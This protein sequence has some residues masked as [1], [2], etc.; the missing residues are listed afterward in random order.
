MSQINDLST[1]YSVDVQK[2]D[3][4]SVHSLSSDSKSIEANKEKTRLLYSIE[5]KS[6][7]NKYALETSCF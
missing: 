3:V 5:I 7:D 1:K 6:L 2:H 4:S